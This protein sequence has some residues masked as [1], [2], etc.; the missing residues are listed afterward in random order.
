MNHYESEATKRARE[1][2]EHLHNEWLDGAEVN[3][4]SLNTLKRKW[5]A[6]KAS[7][8][9]VERIV[10]AQIT[11]LEVFVLA[12]YEAGDEPPIVKVFADREDAEK[13]AKDCEDAAVVYGCA[14]L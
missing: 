6:A 10:R 14:I 12:E 9:V 13:V 8:L 4:R 1:A 7:D 2:F 5:H 11:P 3:H